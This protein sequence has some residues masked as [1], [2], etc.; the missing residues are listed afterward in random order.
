M[1]AIGKVARSFGVASGALVTDAVG[2]AAAFSG[3]GVVASGD[4]G[5]G[6]GSG[7]TDGVAVGLGAVVAGCC[8]CEKPKP[9]MSSGM[10]SS[11]SARGKP[12]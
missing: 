11:P 3:G 9:N 6:V 5:D 8:C 10:A 1:W 2:G 4:A 7:E 12:Q